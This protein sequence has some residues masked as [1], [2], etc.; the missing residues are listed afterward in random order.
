MGEKKGGKA[1]T[2]HFLF[3]KAGVTW[4]CFRAETIKGQS[5]RT[6]IQANKCMCRVQDVVGILFVSAIL[7]ENTKS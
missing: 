4:G 5:K 1:V 2:T 7:W 3:Y 6:G